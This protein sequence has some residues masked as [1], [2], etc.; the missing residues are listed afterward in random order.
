[1]FLFIP[2]ITKKTAFL[3]MFLILVQPFFP[4]DSLVSNSL[5]FDI[6]GQFVSNSTNEIRGITSNV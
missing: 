3:I 5:F 1:M 4:V 2:K 6:F